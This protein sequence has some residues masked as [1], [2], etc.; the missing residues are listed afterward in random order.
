MALE[1]ICEKG[2]S[3][4]MGDLPDPDEPEWIE[5]QPA[6]PVC[7]EEWLNEE[8]EAFYNMCCSVLDGLK[9]KE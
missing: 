2:H 9:E 5:G 1:F 8:H 6:C 4:I 3:Y 7:R